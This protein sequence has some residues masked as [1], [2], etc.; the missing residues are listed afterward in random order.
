MRYLAVVA[1][2]ACAPPPPAPLASHVAAATPTQLAP[3]IQQHAD[4]PTCQLDWN[5]LDE[6]AP[7]RIALAG[8][9]EECPPDFDPKQVLAMCVG[10]ECVQGTTRGGKRAAAVIHGPEGSGHF[11]WIGLAVEG[12]RSTCMMTST[13]G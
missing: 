13:V 5:A 7:G 11:F 3:V 6:G 2:A 1:L 12:G 4:D 9:T 10:D 8:P